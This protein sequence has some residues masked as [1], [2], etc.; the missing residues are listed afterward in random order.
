M[1]ARLSKYSQEK[2]LALVEKAFA[3]GEKAHEGQV[4]KSGEPFFYHPIHVASI[5]VE[6]QLD[7]SS[8]A[9]ALLHDTVEDV[10]EVTLEVIQKEF[11]EEIKQLVDGVTKLGKLD[12]QDREEQQAESWRKMIL[13]MS[14]DIRVIMIKLADRLHNMRTLSYQAPDRQVAIALETLDIYA[15]LAHR[16]GVYSIKSEIEDLALRYIDPQGYRDVATKVGQKRIE[17]EAQITTIIETLR[18][19]LVEMGLQGFDI[20]GRPK[21]LYSIYRKMVI[22]NRH[23]EQI[24]DLIAIRGDC[25]HDT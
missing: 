15:P 17:R 16:L 21:H 22:Q 12:F 23:F 8:V 20:D 24:Y 7:A 6:L 9:A 11:G 2:D 14:K 25:G 19:K 3:F 5:M 1:L 4:R 18:E 13:A 10:E